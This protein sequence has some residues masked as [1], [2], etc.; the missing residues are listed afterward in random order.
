MTDLGAVI[1]KRS[2][3]KTFVVDARRKLNHAYL[4]ISDDGLVREE[5][6]HLAAKKIFCPS[7]CGS[8]ENCVAID[9]NRHPDVL[10]YDGAEMKV[11]K[12]NE[13][14]E[15]ASLRPMR[16][17]KKLF[18]IDNADKLSVQAQNKLLKTYEEPPE[19]VTLI[20]AASGESGILPTVKSRA[21]KLYFDALSP[22]EAAELLVKGGE[23]DE[24]ARLAAAIADGNMEKAE[25]FLFN[26]SNSELYD[27]CFKLLLNLNSSSQIVEYMHCPLFTKENVLTSLDFLEIILSDVL[28]IKTGNEKSVRNVG[29]EYDLREI[30]KKFQPQS[31]AMSIY[32]VNDGRKK[33]NANVNSVTT[34]E[35]VMFDIL[36]ARYKWQL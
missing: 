8:C 7:A 5:F 27:L 12:V 24:R 26:P 17:D 30:A 36:E 32:A 21:K 11:G 33:L 9:E 6:L 22:K 20:L 19:Y 23:S 15:N 4:I 35:S 25:R 28:K 14:T 1:A 3:Y 10:F 31:A 13:L 2:A 34:A 16:G 29:R 18:L